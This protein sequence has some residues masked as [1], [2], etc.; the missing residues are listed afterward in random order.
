[1]LKERDHRFDFKE[2]QPALDAKNRYDKERKY[3]LVSMTLTDVQQ[4]L[5]TTNGNDRRKS[6][7]TTS[8]E[9]P[10]FARDT[11]HAVKLYF[12]RQGDLRVQR[13]S[14]LLLKIP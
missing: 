9:K 10:E 7:T 14:I 8:N 6:G 5:T 3:V 2:E 4:S 12:Q 13:I 11:L 1:M